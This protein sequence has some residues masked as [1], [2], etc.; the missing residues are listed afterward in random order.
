[1]A[2][3]S[4]LQIAKHTVIV[5][6]LTIVTQLGGLAWLA[7]R[8]FRRKIVAFLVIYAALSVTAIFVAPMFGRVPLAC[9][10]NGPLSVHSWLYC[11]TNRNYV[12]PE[13][14]DVLGDLSSSV[15]SAYPGT[16]TRVLDAGFP[17]L[18]SFPLLPHIS[19]DDGEKADLAFFYKDGSGYLPGRAR[20]PIGYFAFEDGP[21]SCPDNLLTLRW[22]LEFLQ[23][24]WPDLELEKQRTAYAV[25]WLARDRRVG[26]VF[27]EPHL[28]RSL[29]ISNSKVRFQG[30]RAARHDD[31]IHVQLR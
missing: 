24:L 31:H 7:S 5:L 12:T 1:M 19:H 21:T 11:L 28:K 10:A 26:K 2:H 8:F 17:F 3:L 4:I 22:D 20:S 30:C 23:P 18:D 13:M 9:G 16:R 6:V 14:R 15:E 25:N 27:I 29:G